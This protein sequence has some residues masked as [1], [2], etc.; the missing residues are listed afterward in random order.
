MELAA[1]RDVPP[2][3]AVRA[4]FSWWGKV[5]MLLYPVRIKFGFLRRNPNLMRT[6][7]GVGQLGYN[8]FT[9]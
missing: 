9:H 6:G 3:L 2:W 5:A 1:G 4:G 8:P 7:Y